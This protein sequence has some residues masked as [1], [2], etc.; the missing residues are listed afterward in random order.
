MAE[1]V[2]SV[3]NKS[4]YYKY[5]LDVSESNVNIT[6]NTSVV[7]A[8]LKIYTNYNGTL[9]SR[10]ASATH[11]ITIDGT[12]YTITTGAYTLGSYNTVTL[13]SASKT[14]THNTD[15]SKTV[16]VSAS[17]PDL[18]QG[19]GWGPYSGSASGNVALT[20]IARYATAN[21]SLNSKT[22]NSIKMNW[23]SDSTCDYIWYSKDN[24]SNW[25]AVGSVNATSG[26]YTISGL[27][28]NTGY[29]IKT[30]VR[31][32]DS[33]LTTDSSTTNVTTYDIGKI[34]SVNNF[35]HGDSTVVNI[36]NPS[37]KWFEFSNEDRQ[38][39]NTK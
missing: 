24:G 27:S 36:T 21:Q 3:S 30:R 4:S 9:A 16:S 13:G 18:A 20:K 10:S 12:N 2:G 15:G 1:I 35:N 5:Y 29:N 26:N 6:N 19:N 32:K 22:I 34:S 39:S 25:V 38:Y 14:V 33:Q 7:T 17:S 11:T 31:R 28:P 23:S 8:T 37:R